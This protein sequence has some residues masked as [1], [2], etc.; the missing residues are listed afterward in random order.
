MRLSGSSNA[1]IHS[2]WRLT[3]FRTALQAPEGVTGYI[4]DVP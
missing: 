4:V 1:Y 2:L 3:S